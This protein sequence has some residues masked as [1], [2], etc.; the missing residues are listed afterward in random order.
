MVR[1]LPWDVR[2]LHEGDIR[3][4][5]HEARS[6]REVGCPKLK[7]NAIWTSRASDHG[8]GCE[9]QHIQRRAA[10]AD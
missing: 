8:T 6:D 5:V 9:R 10:A 3:G 2:S 1:I 7:V 4:H